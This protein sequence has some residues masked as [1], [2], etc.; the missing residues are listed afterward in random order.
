MEGVAFAMAD[1]YAALQGAG[2]TLD[3]ASFIGGGS[4]S[5]FWAKLCATATGVAMRRHHGGD[6]GAALGAARLARLAV[7]KEH[8]S[9]VC[10]SAATIE[11]CE[12][13]VAQRTVTGDRLARY[14]RIY[15]ALKDEFPR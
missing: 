1:G 5:R 3:T 13:D 8:V 2:T 14:R 4:R 6:V 9:Q 15:A 7:A 12:P 11:V 10:T